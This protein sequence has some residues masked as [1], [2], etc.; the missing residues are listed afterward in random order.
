M[1][2]GYSYSWTEQQ[3]ESFEF[4]FQAFLVALFLI[5]FI[6]ISQFNLISKPFIILSSVIMSTAGVFY[7]LVTFQMALG[8]MAM[9][10]IISLAGVVV[11]N[12]IVLIDYI[13]LLRNRDGLDLRTALIEG[14]KVRF[15]PVILTAL[16]TTLDWSRLP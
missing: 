8:L 13:D 15:R 1:P 16:T 7:G 2:S 5:A 4:L 11:N 6:M 12:A 14:G 3:Q 10:G 9:L